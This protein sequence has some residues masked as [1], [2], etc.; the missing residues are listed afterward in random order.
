MIE[1]ALPVLVGICS[2]LYF[3]DFSGPKVLLDHTYQYSVVDQDEPYDSTKEGKPRK[4][5]GTTK[6]ISHPDGITS[7]HDNFLTG[8]EI[9]SSLPFLGTRHEKSGK[10]VWKSYRQTYEAIKNFGSGL[11]KLGIKSKQNVGLYSIN[12]SEWVIAEQACYM[13]DLVTV[14]LYDTLGAE[15]LEY[16]IGLTEMKMVV[17]TADKI[18]SLIEIKEK[19]PTLTVIIA[20]DYKNVTKASSDLAKSKNLQV[21]A[22]EDVQKTG[23]ADVIKRSPTN[24]D[25]IATICFTSGTTGMPKGVLL[26][27]G[28]LLSFVAG[29]HA[30]TTCNYSPSFSKAEVHLSFL[31]LAHIFERVVQ[32]VLI[33]VGAKIGFYGGDTLKLLD[34]VAELKPT[35]FVAVPRLF[36]RIYEKVNQTVVSQGGIKKMLFDYAFSVKKANLAKG[37]VEHK[38]YD[39][40]VFAKIKARLGGNVRFIITGSAPI[41]GEVMDFLRICFSSIVLEGFGQTETS[42]GSTTTHMY[43]FS[44][45]H[46]GAPMPQCLVKLRDVPEMGYTSQSS[47]QKGEICVKGN[48]VFKGYYKQPEKT[49]IFD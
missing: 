32:A 41:S 24:L 37:T 20:M 5:K 36:N 2:F 15:A 43:D 25:S 4:A 10:Y 46:V 26:S 28:N 12:R 8:L 21:V 13:Y 22:F 19:I 38:L 42:G 31:P 1:I 29:I 23:S 35:V 45:G 16:I 7:L 33:N 17:C 48:N 3:Y 39:P 6:L 44:S 14:P 40:L 11:L 30:Q 18:Q 27:H 9:S 34:D 49:G 47:P